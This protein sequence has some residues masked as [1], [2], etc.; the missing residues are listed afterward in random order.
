[1]KRIFLL[2]LF[3]GIF[4]AIN[5]FAVTVDQMNKE[6][7]SLKVV[8][9]KLNALL[10]N[11]EK[12]RLITEKNGGEYNKMLLE[13]A[14]RIRK[15]STEIA[16]MT[17]KWADTKGKENQGM[18]KIIADYE[19]M[20]S[21]HEK[22]FKELENKAQRIDDK[23]KS[24][25]IKLAP[26]VLKK[27]TK[28]E[29]EEFFKY[30]SEPARKEYK[31]NYPDLFSKAINYISG[32]IATPAEAAHLAPCIPECTPATIPLCA[33]C[34]TIFGGNAALD[35]WNTFKKAWDWCGTLSRWWRYGCRTAAVTGYVAWIA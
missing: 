23:I 6:I 31:T 5:A 10:D 4:I 15:S 35:A 17:K 32:L 22:K 27:M 28:E 16:R 8:P 24:G 29:R 25:E 3:C 14:K 30:L 12:S 2:I 13:Y 9:E 34:V 20:A 1:M 26:E 7:S 11:M 33:V 21:E 18:E 19:K